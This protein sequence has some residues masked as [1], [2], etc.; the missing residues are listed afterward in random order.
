MRIKEVEEITG[1]R[2]ANIRYYESEGLLCPERKEDSSY[3]EYSEEDIERLEKIKV[4]RM[5]EVPV[6]D[7]R[8]IFKG[9]LAFEEVMKRQAQRLTDSEALA[10]EKMLNCRKIVDENITLADISESI[11]DAD[12]ELKKQCEDQIASADVDRF[13]FV[14]GALL[15]LAVEG[16]VSA[17]RVVYAMQNGSMDP[18]TTWILPKI[19]IFLIVYGFVWAFIEGRDQSPFM[20]CS[21][22]LQSYWRAPGIGILTNSFSL[23]GLGI[24]M[25]VNNV[26]EFLLY[27]L[28]GCALL[29]GIRGLMNMAFQK[30]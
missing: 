19:G 18:A 15:L 4:L 30:S 27:Y 2:R 6:S 1:L 3:K 25:L 28:A 13:F 16:F 22:G 20:Y 21:I 24:A 10:R 23:A 26:Q 14:K 5:L 7:I 9:T 11:F 8:E 29:C 12:K 17:V